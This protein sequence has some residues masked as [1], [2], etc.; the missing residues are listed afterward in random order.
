MLQWPTISG[1]SPLSLI[2]LVNIPQDFV[3]WI[4]LST[5]WRWR[6]IKGPW[7]HCLHP[8]YGGVCLS[9]C[10]SCGKVLHTWIQCMDMAGGCQL[11]GLPFLLV[12][13][14]THNNTQS[15][16]LKPEI[17]TACKA[18]AVFFGIILSCLMIF[19]TTDLAWWAIPGDIQDHSHQRYP[20]FPG[21]RCWC[22]GQG[23]RRIDHH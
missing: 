18:M 14:W 8:G 15:N 21:V 6:S 1:K 12:P 4:A 19:C 23:Q 11:W 10:T 20:D 9:E 5:L 2:F 13:Q 3:I 7:L 16:C 17:D 22:A